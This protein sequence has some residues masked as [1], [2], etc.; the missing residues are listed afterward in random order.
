MIRISCP[1]CGKRDHSEFSYGG[2]GQINYPSLDA[3]QETWHDAVFLREN[4][5][6]RQIATW[7]QLYGCRS[8]L[9]VARDTRTHEIFSVKLAHPDWQKMMEENR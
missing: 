7:Q 3:A 9:L 1:F 5:Y 8:W 2:D 4:V 6:G